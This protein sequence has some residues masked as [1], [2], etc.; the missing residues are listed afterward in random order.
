M[1]EKHHVY[2]SYE[3]I[4]NGFDEHRSRDLFEKSYLDKV[5]SYLKPKAEILD[6]GCGMGEPI[7]KYFIEQGFKV[8]GIDG[9]K[10]LIDLAKKQ[11]PEGD[12]SVGDMRKASYNKKFDAIIAW[13]S[14]FHLPKPDQRRMFKIFEE[15]SKPN[16]ILLFTS[17]I[18]NGEVW[19]NNGGENLYHASLSPTEYN[20][21]LSQHNYQLLIHT[22]EDK[23]CGDA[24]IWMAQY[25]EK[26]N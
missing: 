15:H 6:L 25:I 14:F 11:L 12:F 2:K 13:N 20:T 3:K 10:N 19:S 21:L 4:A 7:A 24:T 23:D 26:R 18:D 22:V 1:A 17:G 8:T 9:S 16:A 5:I